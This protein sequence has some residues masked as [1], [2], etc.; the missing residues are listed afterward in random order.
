M[1]GYVGRI[2]VHA[3]PRRRLPPAAIREVTAVILPDV[4][5]GPS[6]RCEL[7]H[8]AVHGGEER[9]AITLARAGAHMG[10]VAMC[11]G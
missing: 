7:R 1:P 10:L 8:S 4:A 9:A 5:G 2:R 3:L 6:Q 11:D